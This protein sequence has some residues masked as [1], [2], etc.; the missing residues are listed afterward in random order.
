M[1]FSDGQLPSALYTAQMIRDAEARLIAS[2]E[3]NLC[4][5]ID[6]AGQSAFELLQR[7]GK[8]NSKIL[9]L[10]GYGNNGADAY[11]CAT[12]LLESGCDVALY[13][14]ERSEAGEGISYAKA[15]FLAAGGHQLSDYE[16]ALK[17]AE[18][19]VDGLLGTGVKGELRAPFAEM[20]VAINR[21][22]PWILSLDVPSGIDVDT[23]AGQLAVKA[24]VTLT[25]GAPKQGLITGKARDCVGRLWF[26]DIGLQE[27]LPESKVLNI[28]HRLTDLGLPARAQNS[29]KGA[30]G[31]VTV[32]GGDIGMAGA[33]RLAAESCLRAGA[34]LV[35]VISRPEHLTVVNSGRPEIMFWGCELVDMEVYQRLGWADI[36]LIGPG[37][38]K[39]DWGYNLLKAT[40]LSDKSCVMDA[41]ALNLL[42]LEPSRQSNWV[43][44][45]HSGEAARLLGIS[46]A[47]V[48]ADRFAAV[49]ALQAKYGGVVVLKGAGT[50]IYD[51]KVCHVAPVG[52]PGLASGGS[53][54]VLG[55]IIAALMAQGMAKMEA[56]SAGVVVHGAAA[57]LA[58]KD[59]E[60]G[61]LACDLFAHIRALVDKI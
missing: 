11:I 27:Y 37:L 7:E 30:C 31:K 6:S 39:H 17:E 18:V 9:V 19:V 14:V 21:Y 28:A 22:S 45:P 3:A 34:G 53:G 51:G 8:L 26:A 42:A 48:E 60:R 33:P 57:D 29:H 32:I 50:L 54:D 1:L 47:E 46:I 44:T 23:G 16:E 36:L 25:F 2:G 12:L 4:Q 24:D 40:G 49:Y 43:L 61:M 35:A 13:A 5:L 56:A 52:N 59:G 58:A 38:G 10:A 41:D 20:I 15:A 55:G